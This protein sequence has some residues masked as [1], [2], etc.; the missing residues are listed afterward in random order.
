MNQILALWTCVGVLEVLHYA[1]LAERVQTFGHGGGVDQ[2]TV[3]DLASDHLVELSEKTSLVH[4]VRDGRQQTGMM[5]RGGLGVGAGVAHVCGPASGSGSS[6]GR[7]SAAQK[8]TIQ[9]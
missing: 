5:K 1:R 3:A 2:V 9:H 4:R 8:R 6:P 7:P